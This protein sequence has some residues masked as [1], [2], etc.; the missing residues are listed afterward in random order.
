MRGPCYGRYHGVPPGPAALAGRDQISGWGFGGSALAGR[1]ASA[2][3]AGW[4]CV[5]G[6]GVGTHSAAFVFG[7]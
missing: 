4:E 7:G 5:S 3:G 6:A 2:P 1:V